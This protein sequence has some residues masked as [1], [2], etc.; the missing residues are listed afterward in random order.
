LPAD[1]V[2]A[3]LTQVAEA[4]DFLNTRQ[5]QI[6]GQRVAIQHGDVKPN[7]ML[8]FGDTVRLSDFGL[9]SRTC[10]LMERHIPQG[11]LD[12]AAPEIFYGIVSNHS[13]QYSLAVSYF[14]LRTGRLPFPSVQG[15]SFNANW[16]RVRPKPNLSLLSP[17]EQLIIA[18]A[19]SLVPQDRWSSSGQ[20]MKQ[21][22]QVA[23]EA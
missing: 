20:M 10:S 2:C 11:T 7:N 13:D 3:Y 17:A 8:L 14:M 15:S 6:E 4:L 16:P 5:H 22:S 18:R 23:I 1:Q 21:L 12:Y 19:L 9:A